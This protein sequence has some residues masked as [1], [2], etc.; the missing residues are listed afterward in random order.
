MEEEASLAERWI[1]IQVCREFNEPSGAMRYYQSGRIYSQR[2]GLMGVEA[3]N[4]PGT[5]V[6]KDLDIRL[7]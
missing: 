2:C 1:N 7:R 3:G 6:H 4:M 5:R